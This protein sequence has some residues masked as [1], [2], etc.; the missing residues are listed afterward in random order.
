[1]PVTDLGEKPFWREPMRIMDLA[2]E[3]SHGSWLNRWTAE[4]AVETAL[5]LN[6]NVLN[7]MVVNEWGQAYWPSPHLPMQPELRGQ[8]RFRAVAELARQAGLRV[9]GMWGPSPA[10]VQ[11]QRHPDWAYRSRD[12]RKVGWG[13]IADEKCFHVC[14][15]SPYE[16]LVNQALEQLFR[17]Y[18]IDL[19]ALDYYIQ[20]PC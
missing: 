9:S 11:S 13:A 6:A 16:D 17:D 20:D 14:T 5:R 18:P 10:P 8:D 1:M 12:G 19:L 2:L 15:N 3:D 7:M 4:W